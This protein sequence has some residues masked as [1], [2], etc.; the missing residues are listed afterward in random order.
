M[1]K[2]PDGQLLPSTFDN[3]TKLLRFNKQEYVGVVTYGL[4]A[5]G[6]NNPRT[7]HSYIPEFEA[8]IAKE[9]RIGIQEFARRLSVFFMDRWKK[10][11]MPEMKDYKGPAMTFLLAGYD[12]N[13]PY[14][15]VYEFSIPGQP[16]PKEWHPGNSFGAVWGG[17]Q[18]FVGRL[19]HGYDPLVPMVIQDHLKLTPEQ[20]L[21]LKETLQAVQVNIPY[22]FLPL[23]DCI[24]LSVLLIRTTIEMQSFYVGVRGVGG[25][26][27][28]ATITKTGGYQSVKEKSVAK[29]FNQRC[30][31]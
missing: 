9:K 2:L 27:D 17:Q 12:E 29:L 30:T 4:G 31:Q 16:D 14:G 1:A 6:G 11:G 15:C 21:K 7:A 19:I 25:E 8:Q 3:T 5:L 10:Q 23:Q 28:V 20:T 13:A 22:Q 18:D 26:I 24:N